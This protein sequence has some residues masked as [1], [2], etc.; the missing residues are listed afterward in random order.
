MKSLTFINC[1]GLLALTV[2]CVAQ[3]QDNRQFNMEIV[4][5]ESLRVDLQEKLNE[6]DATL[7]GNMED[8]KDLKGQIIKLTDKYRSNQGDLRLAE[9]KIDQLSYERDQLKENVKSWAQAVEE[10]DERIKENQ[11]QMM[12]LVRRLNEVTQKYNELAT[13]YN[14]TVALLNQRTAALN[15]QRR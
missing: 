8:I 5:L 1:A 10:R 13:N 14:E 11:E 3:W 4:R 7:A 12:D 2:L 9:Q 6:R 15:E